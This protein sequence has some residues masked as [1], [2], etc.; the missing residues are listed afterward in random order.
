MAQVCPGPPYGTRLTG[1]PRPR[2]NDS[3]SRHE[4][5][6]A[7][8]FLPEVREVVHG[9]PGLPLV[10]RALTQLTH[11]IRSLVEKGQM[12]KNLPAILS[13]RLRRKPHLG[14]VELPLV[15]GHAGAAIDPG[16]LPLPD[17]R[18]VEVEALSGATLSPC[19][20]LEQDAAVKDELDA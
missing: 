8:L 3:S 18:V 12:V 2:A 4:T 5:Y 19:P 13:V 11:L 7:G 9:G 15:L 20:V 14:A 17:R 1:F 16:L 10:A 6:R